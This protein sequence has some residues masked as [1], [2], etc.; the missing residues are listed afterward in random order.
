MN[1]PLMTR[2]ERL[3]ALFAENPDAVVCG[4]GS[5]IRHDGRCWVHVTTGLPRCVGTAELRVA[6]PRS[7]QQVLPIA[8][9]EEVAA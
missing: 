9:T 6:A 1:Q 7:G 3:A 8:T 4:C 2:P 5:P